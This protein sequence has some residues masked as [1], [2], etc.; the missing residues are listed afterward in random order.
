MTEA[1][2]GLD[3]LVGASVEYKGIGRNLSADDSLAQPVAG[4]GDQYN[5]VGEIKHA[6]SWC[7]HK[8]R[9]V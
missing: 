8:E 2:G 9:P 6:G 7:N 3:H 4:A 1:D 5:F